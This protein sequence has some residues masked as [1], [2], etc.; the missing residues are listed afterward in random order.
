MN[1]FHRKHDAKHHPEQQPLLADEHPEEDEEPE[2]SPPPPP[3]GIWPKVKYFFA[4]IPYMARDLFDRV[5]YVSVENSRKAYR[6][7]GRNIKQILLAFVL[8]LIAIIVAM[9]LGFLTHQ[10]GHT[11]KALCTS[12]ACVHAA[13]QL[14]YSL[15]PQYT[16]IDPC[17][18]FDQLACQGF[19]D[20]HD[21]RPDQSDMFRGTLM[22][23]EAEATL[24]HILETDPSGIDSADAE[25]FGKLKAN[26][27]A[28]MDEGTVKAS[29]LRPL[30]QMVDHIKSIYSVSRETNMWR[31]S[32][33]LQT[34]AGLSSPS[35]EL[36][37]AYLYMVSNGV[38]AL[39]Y[40]F[41]GVSRLMDLQQ[42]IL[43]FS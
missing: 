2:S 28:C 35:K 1:R 26:Y 17:T 8:T 29:G 31:A 36:A 34:V 40:V 10:K 43:T 18:H 37:K 15:S 30:K 33:I 3:G 16:E 42:F 4:V 5:S 23:E 11:Q 39:T 22:A 27:D 13:S 14:L 12:P 6:A 25:N 20:R 21:L 41:V 7:C 32:P 9:S 19:E 38:G 24:R